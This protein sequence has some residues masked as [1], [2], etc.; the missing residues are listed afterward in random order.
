[1]L[2]SELELQI[3]YLKILNKGSAFYKFSPQDFPKVLE[4]DQHFSID[5]ENIAPER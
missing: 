1:M 4:I 3:S 5:K 2:S